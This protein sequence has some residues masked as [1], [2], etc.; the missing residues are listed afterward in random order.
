MKLTLYKFIFIFTL[1]F[2]ASESAKS[3]LAK[4]PV[5]KAMQLEVNRSKEGLK[6]DSLARP[7]F[8]SLLVNETNL[9]YTYSTSFGKKNEET[10]NTRISRSGS[11]LILVGNYHRTQNF[12]G[13]AGKF[14]L[15]PSNDVPA[16]RTAIWMNL[17]NTYKVAAKNYVDKM[18]WLKQEKLSEEE[19]A[20]NDFEKR[21]AVVLIQEQEKKDFNFNV[22]KKL[23]LQTGKLLTR[24]VKKEKLQVEALRTGFRFSSELI[25]YYDTEGSMYKYPLQNGTFNITLSG[26]TEDG[27]DV[28]SYKSFTI[29]DL[30]KFPSASELEKAV[31]EMIEEYKLKYTAPKSEDPYMGPVLIVGGQIE[32]VTKQIINNLYTVPKNRF[33]NGN[34]Y[35]NLTESEFCPSCF[36]AFCPLRSSTSYSGRKERPRSIDPQAVIPPDSIVLI[37][38]GILKTCLPHANRLRNIFNQMEMPKTEER[39][40]V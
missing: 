11:P 32:D 35:Q 27:E 37:Q 2:F 3:E 25:R 1:V 6:K 36:F 26:V 20:L 15:P 8:I 39:L 38:N 13:N 29:N 34:H 9:Q 30:S 24:R 18:A 28:G 21:E 22:I 16:L 5:L 14:Q 33:S 23:S 31:D 10:V 4:D 7:F 12:R 19:L 40:M 17:D